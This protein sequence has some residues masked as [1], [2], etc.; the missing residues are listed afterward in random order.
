MTKENQTIEEKIAYMKG[1][2]DGQ[3]VELNRELE[4]LKNPEKALFWARQHLFKMI[5]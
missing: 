2:Y 5:K 4:H 3:S 1:F